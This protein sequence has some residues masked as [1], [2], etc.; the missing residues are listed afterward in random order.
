MLGQEVGGGRTETYYRKAL[1]A[2]MTFG[3]NGQT[4]TAT[5]EEY[6]RSVGGG[7]SASDGLDP[8]QAGGLAARLSERE[9]RGTL[10]V[11]KLGGALGGGGSVQVSVVSQQQQQQQQLEQQ[12]PGPTGEAAAAAAEGAAAVQ[13]VAEPE[14]PRTT[15]QPAA[16]AAVQVAAAQLAATQAAAAFASQAAA[17]AAAG[18]GAGGGLQAAVERVPEPEPVGAEAL[19]AWYSNVVGAGGERLPKP[20]KGERDNSASLSTASEWPILSLSAAG[21]W[22]VA[23]VACCVRP[24]AVF[25]APRMAGC[26]LLCPPSPASILGLLSLLPLLFSP[27]L[28]LSPLACSLTVRPLALSVSSP[29][30]AAVT[31]DESAV[32]DNPGCKI[33]V[34]DV[35]KEWGHRWGAGSC[36]LADPR[37]WPFG[38]PGRGIDG[39]D[40]LAPEAYQYSMEHWIGQ[41][42]M[43]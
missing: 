42:N 34:L 14:D 36:D 22:T 24:P 8:D 17:A 18:A 19:S 11:G 15:H 7:G 21:S 6:H 26:W 2:K 39:A 5:S 12:Q 38:A 1:V 13:P 28:P 10:E 9:E 20:S 40:A 41:V 35:D 32:A 25:P 4:V 37:Q 27:W 43:Y 3:R 16:E 31:F 33:A 29:C 30:T 23:I